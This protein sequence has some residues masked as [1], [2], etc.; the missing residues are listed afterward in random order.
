M[1][2]LIRNSQWRY[3]AA[4]HVVASTVLAAI[5]IS[6]VFQVE[7]SRQT[8]QLHT[9]AELKS[10]QIEHW[11]SERLSDA[12]ILASRQRIADLR[13][14][15]QSKNDHTAKA[16]LINLLNQYINSQQYQTVLLLDARGTLLTSVGPTTAE[17]SPQLRAVVQQVIALQKVQR[18]E[19]YQV[20]E[21]NSKGKIDFVAPITSSIDGS[22]S[23]VVLRVE[24]GDFL[25]PYIQSWPVPTQTGEALV[26]RRNGDLVEFLHELKFLP[27]KGV[28]QLPMSTQDLPSART[29]RGEVAVGDS[30]QGKDYRQEPVLGAIQ[31]IQGSDW[32]LIAKMD[33][34]EI[35]RGAYENVGLIT[36]AWLLFLIGGFAILRIIRQ[37][38][39]ARLNQSKQTAQEAE[40]RALSF[41]EGLLNA[42]PVAVFYKD[43][44][45]RYLGC[46]WIF[47][48]ILGVKE[49]DLIGKT[50]FELWPN[51][52]ADVYHRKDL[53]LIEN[54]SPQ[55]YEYAISDKDGRLRDVIYS[56]NVFRDERGEVA[57]IVGTFIDITENKQNV[58]ELNRYRLHLEETVREQ[59]HELQQ[60]NADLMGAKERAE[61]ASHAKSAFLANMSH[62]I[63]TPLNG[64]IGF[65]QLLQR[66]LTAP[67]QLEKIGK[68]THAAQHLLS[69]INDILDLSK[70]EANRIELDNHAFSLPH[71]FDTISGLNL[72][73]AKNK[74]IT[75]QT[76]IDERIP[77]IVFGD[78]LRIRQ[79][80][81]NFSSNALKF[82]K[83]GTI[84]LR[85]K[86][87]A[88]QSDE[89]RIRFEVQDSGIGL[90]EAAKQKLFQPFEQA[91]TST[92]RQYGGTGLGLA[93][94][95]KL[96]E[97]MNG[98]VGVE[99]VDGKGSV[100]WF[101]VSFKSVPEGTELADTPITIGQAF[102]GEPNSVVYPFSGTILLVE[103]NEVNQEVAIEILQATG[104]DVV[105]ANHGQEALNHIHQK[106]N[107][108]R[109][110]DL[111][112]MDM[113]MPIMDGLDAT[114]AI[115]L[116]PQYQAAP[117]VAMTANAFV[118]DQQ[119]CIAAGMN[120]HLAK[121]ITIDGLLGMV[122]K[123]W[124]HQ[125]PF[126]DTK[127]ATVSGTSHDDH[128]LAALRTAKG[129]DVSA[130]IKALSG[131]PAGYI[132]MLKKLLNYH[133]D[134]VR[135]LHRLIEAGDV[136]SAK[137]LMH[138]T[139]G[140]FATLGGIRIAQAASQL[141]KS[142]GE[143]ILSANISTEI[144]AFANAHQEFFSSLHQIFDT[145]EKP[146]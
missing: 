88:P 20:A 146:Q 92:T 136:E 123:W 108:G 69:L 79:V 102:V 11:L 97:L 43:R 12:S 22:L 23:L 45:G 121:P 141:E 86:Y 107:E 116:L 110:F 104:L 54:P 130:G 31:K 145:H 105:V 124:P 63:R 38:E 25:R 109:I 75:W 122:R 16:K 59:T 139:K 21:S 15:W 62:E 27:Q 103:D 143:K 74:G 118:E 50:A 10:Q 142:L 56:K 111:I 126:N 72:P 32:Y 91:D 53:A 100:F 57:G 18:T 37:Q 65:S 60:K 133:Q 44:E 3:W 7:N 113:Q 83:T 119:R 41:K 99:S 39:E 115:R 66:E 9:I 4:A 5:G 134:D 94:S 81:L 14:Q 67:R 77:S 26:F 78:S 13:L 42:I 82:T 114:K 71:I 2:L 73:L 58:A 89:I 101:E 132:R 24:V 112:L 80:L 55:S 48:K 138:S 137:R 93:I 34:K 8:A 51:D 140:S 84:T 40:L 28:I 52:M 96:A 95:R 33:R 144:D 76:E 120:D 29:L 35:N 68:V 87:L 64:I 127:V 117:I 61:E 98:T 85:A 131:K 135:N 106:A 1:K 70:I 47:S 125:L 129:L 90:S 17:I 36:L 46:N 30:I 128:L 49:A 6:S 19:I